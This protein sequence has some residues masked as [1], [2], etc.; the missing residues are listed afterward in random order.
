MFLMWTIFIIFT[1]F[2]T[3]LLLCYVLFCFLGHKAGGIKPAPLALEGKVLATGAPGKS[4][5]WRF[6]KAWCFHFPLTLLPLG[7][8]ISLVDDAPSAK[9]LE[10]EMHEADTNLTSRLESDQ[11]LTCEYEINVCHGAIKTLHLFA[12][13]RYQSKR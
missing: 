2:V 4:P 9:I 12:M 10:G 8:P 6:L 3:I 7:T 5:G 1:G 13:W 11:Q